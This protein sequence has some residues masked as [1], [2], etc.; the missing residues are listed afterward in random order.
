MRFIWG[1]LIQNDG[2]HVCWWSKGNPYL[3]PMLRYLHVWMLRPEIIEEILENPKNHSKAGNIGEVGGGK[4]PVKLPHAMIKTKSRPCPFNY[5]N[6]GFQLVQDLFPVAKKF[7]FARREPKGL[8]C[9]SDEHWFEPETM[10]RPILAVL[11]V[12]TLSFWET[13]E[14][15]LDPQGGNAYQRTVPPIGDSQ[16]ATANQRTHACQSAIDAG[17]I[18]VFPVAGWLFLLA[19]IPFRISRGGVTLSAGRDSF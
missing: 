1:N 3:G 18:T 5:P 6:R 7:D 17:P 12:W 9:Q 10:G 14:F 4:F 2:P 19:G 16:S 13:V 15:P 8:S 11:H